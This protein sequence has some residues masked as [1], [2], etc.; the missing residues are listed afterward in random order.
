[1]KVDPKIQTAIEEAVREAKQGDGVARKLV[2]WFK[3][4]ASGNEDIGNMN[5]AR[6]HAELLYKATDHT[7]PPVVT[8]DERPRVE[9]ML[10]NGDQEETS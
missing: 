9:E 6:R 5:S 4:V 2:A 7:K 8:E 1:M 3:E 10:N